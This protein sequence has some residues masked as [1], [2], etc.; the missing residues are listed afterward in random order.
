MT[1]S[2]FAFGSR[3]RRTNWTNGNA[4]GRDR[5]RGRQAPDEPAWLALTFSLYAGSTRPSPL[6]S[7]DLRSLAPL[8]A[9]HDPIDID[10]D[11]IKTGYL[12]PLS[13]D[14][15]SGA[16]PARPRTDHRVVQLVRRWLRPVGRLPLALAL[17]PRQRQERDDNLPSSAWPTSVAS[18]PTLTMETV[19][20]E[21]ARVEDIK[22]GWQLVFSFLG[23]VN[24]PF[25]ERQQSLEK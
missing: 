18:S 9:G 15:S 19:F 13:K 3:S 14:D 4:D 22:A 23:V 20:I 7:F 17:Q 21:E 10:V 8:E 5:S 1:C 11:L 12:P 25:E 24:H 2:S 16:K 6:P